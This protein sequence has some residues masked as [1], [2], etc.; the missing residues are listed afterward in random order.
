ME[1]IIFSLKFLIFSFCPLHL[2]ALFMSP[3]SEDLRLY[4]EH[5]P[6]GTGEMTVVS[7]CIRP[8][9]R[10]RTPPILVL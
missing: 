8:L 7:V 10:L 4:P 1:P 5:S 3:V 6:E 9:Q 2:K